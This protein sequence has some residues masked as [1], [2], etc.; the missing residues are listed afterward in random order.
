MCVHRGWEVAG[1]SKRRPEPPAQA[2]SGTPCSSQDLLQIQSTHNHHP[3]LG[4]GGPGARQRGNREEG[5][6]GGHWLKAGQGQGKDPS[7]RQGG[8]E[9]QV[10]QTGSWVGQGGH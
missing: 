7:W 1:F 10:A 4:D 9:G 3:P 2:G 6:E 8:R 5:S